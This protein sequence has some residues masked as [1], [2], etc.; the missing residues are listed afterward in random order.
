[1]RRNVVWHDGA[2]FTSAD[3]KF[4]YDALVNPNNNVA[5]RHGYDL[6]RDVTTPDPYTVVVRMKRRY[7]AAV[8]NFFSD[9]APNP[10]LPRHLL[11]SYA[12]LNRVPFNQAPVGTGPYK[13]LR[14]D[15]GQSIELVA[16]DRYYL[17]GRRSRA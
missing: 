14:W 6:I 17:G 16:N 3:V 8:T 13:L 10:I 11:A 7:A 4:S 1:M 15:H 5:S 2:P 9:A 12:D